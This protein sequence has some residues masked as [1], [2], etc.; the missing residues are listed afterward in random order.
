MKRMILITITSFT[1]LLAGCWDQN[2]LINKKF[3]NGISFDSTKD[4]KIF[5]TVR[6]LSIQS[7][8]GGL[9]DVKDEIVE[10]TRPSVAGMSIDLN[11]KLPGQIDASKAYIIL[12]G[13]ELAKKGIHPLLDVFYRNKNAYV[14]SRVVI[15]KGKASEILALEPETSPIAFVILKGLLSGERTTRIPKE[16]VFT[17]WTKIVDPGKDI[18]LPL[19]DKDKSNKIIIKGIDLF[20][21]DKYSGISLTG[22]DSSLLLLLMNRL[23]KDSE[24]VLEL[25]KKRAASFAV[26]HLKRDLKVK[27]TK[28]HKIIGKVNLILNVSLTTYSNNPTEKV[29]IDKLN[30]ELSAELS[31]QAKIVT[32]SLIK[33]NCDALGVGRKLA[34]K[35]P[36][37]WKKLNWKKDYKN[38][39]FETKV[40]VVIYKTGSVF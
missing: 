11:N 3:V 9:F 27:V 19:I 12:I 38:V 34:S 28:S 35:H 15:T 1:C 2:L 40:K 22:T 10:A 16:T 39:E 25:D 31:K 4:D 36:D 33:A 30:K 37:F 26:T 13:Q 32:D 7:K 21:G 8:G 17:S 6:A 18:V 29:N 5:G 23:E 20:D 24:I 14:A